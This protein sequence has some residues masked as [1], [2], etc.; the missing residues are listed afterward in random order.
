M[1][2]LFSYLSLALVLLL[3]FACDLQVPKAIQVKGNPE[4]KFAVKSW[5]IDLF[6]DIMASALGDNDNTQIF[7]CI[8]APTYKTFLIRM[9]L[10]DSELEL[11]DPLGGVVININ[12]GDYSIDNQ[13]II[14]TLQEPV[15]LASSDPDEPVTVTLSFSNFN[16]SMPGFKFKKESIKS[17]LYISG[18][19]IV[20]IFTVEFKTN[21]STDQMKVTNNYDL[22]DNAHTTMTVLPDGGI[23]VDI[24]DLI[25]SGDDAEIE[26]KVF[27]EKDK[28]IR[29]EWLNTHNFKGEL[30]IWIPMELEAGDDG[31]DINFNKLGSFEGFGDFFTSLSEYGYIKSIDLSIGMNV[32]P[33]MNGILI[34]EDDNY[35][36][37]NPMGEKTIN[38]AFSEDDVNYI[39]NNSFDPELIFS[40]G[41][42]AIVRVPKTFSLTT[43]ALKA[44]LEYTLEF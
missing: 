39:N 1:K 32:N 3:I 23:N 8:N 28:D 5:E 34:I 22:P 31:A 30:V 18:S 24:A 36:I 20:T 21:I 37:E 25:S 38:F 4:L 43:V 2:N 44:G 29:R 42:K 17:K 26:F 27:I 10:F 13:D 9:E 11:E 7:E 33:F 41:P 6:S 14:F 35:K 19:E 15:Y 40:F 12:G 16:D